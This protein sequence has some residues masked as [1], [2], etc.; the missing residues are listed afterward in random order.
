MS[1][2][3]LTKAVIARLETF[4]FDPTRTWAWVLK[5]WSVHVGQ[6]LYLPK[7]APKNG[8]LPKSPLIKIGSL[9][10]SV[11]TISINEID[12]QFCRGCHRR[13]CFL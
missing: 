9:M 4:R 13:L 8:N 1:P 5:Q 10:P 11:G 6:A 7:A 2:H 12:V 3:G